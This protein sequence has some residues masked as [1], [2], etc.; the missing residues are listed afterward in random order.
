[1]NLL[2][3]SAECYTETELALMKERARVQV[4][5]S[6]IVNELPH[7]IVK[8]HKTITPEFL[9]DLYAIVDAGLSV[10]QS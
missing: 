7:V 4:L 2:D 3:Y 6:L 8:H 10:N 5:K 1:M 9:D